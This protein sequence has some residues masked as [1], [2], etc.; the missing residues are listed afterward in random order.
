MPSYKMLNYVLMPSHSIC[1]RDWKVRSV[2]ICTE[3][4]AEL[5]RQG[6]VI[7]FKGWGLMNCMC[8]S[9]QQI[10][11][12]K[13]ERMCAVSEGSLM[14]IVETTLLA[15]QNQK[16]SKYLFQHFHLLQW[17]TPSIRFQQVNSV[18]PLS[19]GYLFHPFLLA[20]ALCLLPVFFFIPVLILMNYE[21]FL[22]LVLSGASSCSLSSELIITPIFVIGHE[23][24]ETCSRQCLM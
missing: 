24:I 16:L 21:G 4:E 11:N 6:A 17:Y 8:C 9:C 3:N 12:R 22:I 20:F 10:C 5:C 2:C 15:N 13:C 14:G 7:L 18:I 1:C 23:E 19:Y